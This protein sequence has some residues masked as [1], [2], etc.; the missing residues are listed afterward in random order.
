MP[1]YLAVRP[2]ATGYQSGDFAVDR[3]A[4]AVEFAAS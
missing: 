3:G 4:I 2:S 1:K